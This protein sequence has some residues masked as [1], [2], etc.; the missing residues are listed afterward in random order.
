MHRSTWILPPLFELCSFKN[1][2]LLLLQLLHWLCYNSQTV[3]YFP[4]IT[5]PNHALC[6]NPREHPRRESFICCT[7]FLAVGNLFAKTPAEYSAIT[8]LP[9]LLRSLVSIHFSMVVH[10]IRG[11]PP[12][13]L[14][15]AAPG[16][17]RRLALERW[18]VLPAEDTAPL[19]TWA[20]CDRGRS[21]RAESQRVYLTRRSVL[22]HFPDAP[23]GEGGLPPAAGPQR[24]IYMDLT[25]THLR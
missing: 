1:L 16:P 25:W 18:A 6:N 4:L 20:S 10:G 3:D 21:D 19:N 8:A 15:S 7:C 12:P 13:T 2:L 11:A 14:T 24:G 9:S 22:P 17:L 5:F 23:L